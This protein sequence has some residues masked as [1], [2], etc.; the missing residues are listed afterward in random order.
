MRSGGGSGTASRLC[1]RG[2]CSSAR[3]RQL[4]R[5]SRLPPGDW[6][7]TI[8]T[9][10]SAKPPADQGDHSRDLAEDSPVLAA[11]GPEKAVWVDLLGP[12]QAQLEE[13]RQALGFSPEVITQ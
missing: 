12:D 6:R 1:M 8:M 2:T 11:R 5:S 13:V 7:R 4:R 10:L 3:E 9:L